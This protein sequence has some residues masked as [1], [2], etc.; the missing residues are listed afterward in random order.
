MRTYGTKNRATAMLYLW[1]VRLSW[2][3]MLCSGVS[4]FNVRALPRLTLSR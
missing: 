3:T 1:P 2:V 4:L